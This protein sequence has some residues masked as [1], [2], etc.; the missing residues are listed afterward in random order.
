[1]AA[2]K[3]RDILIKIDVGGGTYTAIGG[4]RAKQLRLNNAPVDVSDADSS[5][6]WRELMMGA[7][8]KSVEV[9]GSGVFKDSATETQLTTTLTNSLT[10]N[11]QMVLPGVGTF[12]GAFAVPQISYGGN[13][14]GEMTF[15]ATFQS[16]GAITF[17]PS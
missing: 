7:A 11:F 5:N 16:A 12:Q 3:G 1:M 8:L 9:S 15:D 17:T 2:Q 13:H 4:M 6:Q 14:E 10:P